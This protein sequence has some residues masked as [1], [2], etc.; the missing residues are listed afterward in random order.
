MNTKL[1]EKGEKS[2]AICES[3][4]QIVS[5]TFAQRDV[6]FSDGKG[7]VKDIL[8]A[9]CGLCNQVVAVPA[10]SI[11]AIREARLKEVKATKA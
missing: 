3:C 4:R 10:Q 6:P 5:T 8:V 9:V 7:E 11:P 2:K 1:N